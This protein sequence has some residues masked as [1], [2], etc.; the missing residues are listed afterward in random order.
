M[1]RNTIV[2]RCE[3]RFLDT[4]NKIVT[5]TEWADY[6]NEAYMDVVGAHPDWPFLEA[7]SEVVSVP[8]GTGTAT[9][10]SD[11]FRVTAVYNATDDYVLEPLDGRS[12]HFRHF[13]D[14]AANLGTPTVYRLRSN[15]LEVY[16]WPSVTT[17]L[18]VDHFA[19]PAT[20]GATDEPVFPEQ[21]HRILVEGAIARAYEDQGEP[22]RAVSYQTRFNR[23]LRD[24]LVDLLGP[25][26]ESY[27]AILD[28][29]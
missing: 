3:A 11:A 6:V 27:P 21:Y 7:R 23:M 19:P 28:V 14:P 12:S 1:N 26:T 9:L 20:L 22:D 17:T 25:R 24:M 18:H 5:A 4:A 16:P 2:D 29:G 8:A 13:P 10:P 15:V